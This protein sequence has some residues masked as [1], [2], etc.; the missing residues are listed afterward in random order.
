MTVSKDKY[1]TKPLYDELKDG[2]KVTILP[3]N[4]FE[5]TPNNVVN[6][7]FELFNEIIDE[8]ITYVQEDQVDM[9][10]FKDYYFP[11]FVAVMFKGV[12]KEEDRLN[13]HLD[14]KIGGK[15]EFLGC[16][17]IKPNYI[18]R[19]NHICNAGFLVSFNNRGKSCGSVM[20]RNYLKLAPLLG[21]KSSVFNLVYESNI[22]SCKIWDNLGFDR[23]GRISKAGRMKG[24]NE[25]VDAVMFGYQFE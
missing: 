9:K 14:I 11:H 15:N 10:E 13:N 23:I 22:A 12:I 25:L 17:Y 24:G 18:G 21:F 20:G 7:I 16:F 5:E 19:S 8:G 1:I 6:M 3:F 4:S 2:T